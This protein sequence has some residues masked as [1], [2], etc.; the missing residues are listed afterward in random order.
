MMNYPDFFNDI[1]TIKLQDPLSEFLGA[2]ENG[3]VE[4]SYLDVVKSAGHSCPTVA[5]AYIMTLVGLKNLYKNSIPK[6]GEI[7]VSFKEKPNEGVAGVI[8]NV[9]SQITGST[10]TNGFKGLNGKFA[11]TN[12]LNFEE[13][14]TSCVRFS[15]VDTNAYIDINYN[16][17]IISQDLQIPELMQ[18]LLQNNSTISERKLFQK[19]WQKRV[20]LIFQNID[21]VIEVL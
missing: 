6:R 10:A 19:L 16:P 1:E 2:F 12:L 17:N 4:F 18:K 9:I 21:K 7:T 20:E 11:R 14:I 15:R 5:G 8:G 3:M 13:D